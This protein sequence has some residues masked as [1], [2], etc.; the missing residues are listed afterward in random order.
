MI[1]LSRVP[2]APCSVDNKRLLATVTG[3][4]APQWHIKNKTQPNKATGIGLSRGLLLPIFL[5]IWQRLPPF[6][7]GMG[8][9]VITSSLSWVPFLSD[10]LKRKNSP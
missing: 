5:C 4:V 10:R 3:I 9:S 2:P 7:T 8:C 6:K 1:D